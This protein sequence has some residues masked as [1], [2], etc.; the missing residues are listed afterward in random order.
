MGAS[1]RERARR[2]R[3]GK[4]GTYRNGRARACGAVADAVDST[5]T[6]WRG[7]SGVGAR[8]GS[9]L[10]SHR[11][12]CASSWHRKCLRCVPR[13]RRSGCR[14]RRHHQLKLIL[15]TLQSV[16]GTR[17]QVGRSPRNALHCVKIRLRK[18]KLMTP[19]LVEAFGHEGVRTYFSSCPQ[20]QGPYH[21]CVRSKSKSM[22]VQQLERRRLP[23]VYWDW[24]EA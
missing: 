15:G 19:A 4:N 8:R 1:G 3:K 10:R 2:K 13:G 24:P 20:L 14:S 17:S 23:P 7:G 16:S 11:L 12:K 18:P 22:N 21:V 5:R 9:R 6:R